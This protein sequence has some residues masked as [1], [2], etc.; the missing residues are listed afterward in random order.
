M[1]LQTES[2]RMSQISNLSLDLSK[3]PS[4]FMVPPAS[5]KGATFAPLAGSPRANLRGHRRISSVSNYASQNYDDQTGEFLSSP[6][7]SAFVT[8]ELRPPADK[9]RIS[10]I[11]GG[12]VSPPERFLDIPGAS[13]AQLEAMKRELETTKAELEHARNDIAEAYEAKEASEQC[14][15]ALRTFIVENAVGESTARDA[16]MRPKSVP[17]DARTQTEQ[18]K[19][20]GWS[21]LKLWRADTASTTQAPASMT[22]SAAAGD[23]PSLASATTP[24]VPLSKVIGGFFSGRGS[25]S[26]ETPRKQD[27]RPY[28]HQEPM[29]NGSDTDSDHEP[30]PLSP[31]T[32]PTSTHGSVFV[33]DISSIFSNS[34]V[35]SSLE[36]SAVKSAVSS[37]AVPKPLPAQSTE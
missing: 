35:T 21:A 6:S 19:A 16:E 28:N 17:V 34:G 20:A 4:A 1:R 14:V 10:G 27:G 3:S 24:A 13:S 29:L 37:E 30:E 15:K 33:H 23:S 7:Q 12:R 18:K 31:E 22:F 36:P 8:D 26:S 5:S 11:F 2:R 9:R 25:F 32:Y